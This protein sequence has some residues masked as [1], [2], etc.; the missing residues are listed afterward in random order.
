MIHTHKEFDSHETVAVCT[1]QESGLK[2]IIAVHDTNA[3][4]AMGGCRI[5][6]Y[7]EFEQ[8]LTDVLRLSK[9]MTYKNI[10]AGLP[11][12]G[13]KAVIIADPRKDKTPK[14]IIAF[15]HRVAQLGGTFIT[16]EDVG[17]T[18]ADVE[19]MR[20]VTP[21]VRGIPQN[22]PGDPSPMT[23]RGVFGG[24]EAAVQHRLGKGDL[25][26]TS[27]I[28]QGL[29]AVGWA[30]AELLHRAGA[31]LIVSDVDGE[32]VERARK[33]FGAAAVD[34]GRCH[35]AA[36]DV[37]APCALGGGLNEQTIAEIQTSI[38]A[39]AANNQLATSQDGARLA[40]RGVL[41][42]PDFVVNAGGVIST[43][44]EG[45]GFDN[46]ILLARVTGIATTLRE[47][48]ARADLEKLP[49]SQVASELAK[50]R[51]A[52]ARAAKHQFGRQTLTGLST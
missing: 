40:S 27:I 10:M 30:L 24:I 39:G 1:D 35:A 17:T 8:A 5:V 32:K 41:Y 34:P 36:A 37:Y 26:G 44:L 13:G 42:A 15:A 11:Y 48:F 7:P 4:P 20:Q 46:A 21:H 14:L 28:V 38:V 33:A 2:A 3:G 12:G 25:S 47:I 6:P 50:E 19:L 23:A 52:E 22:G 18:V 45:P 49:T 31:R 43:A 51:L 29:G 9:G 16:G